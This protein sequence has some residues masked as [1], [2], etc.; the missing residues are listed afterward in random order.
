MKDAM[1]FH[2]P[3]NRD[4]GAEN[5]L[6]FVFAALFIASGCL[7]LT[8][9]TA[10]TLVGSTVSRYLNVAKGVFLF[11]IGLLL[12]GLA[13]A[14]IGILFFTARSAAVVKTP[15]FMHI[16]GEMEEE[17][18]LK[19]WAPLLIILALAVPLRLYGLNSDLWYDEV[20]T[21]V[22]FVRLPVFQLL[23][24]Y[25]DQ[26]NHPLFSLMAH[27]SVGVFGESAWALRV[28]AFVFGLGSLWALFLLARIVTNQREAI[29][30]TLLAAV[31]YH[32]VWFSQNA[33]GYTGLLFWGLLG[34]WLF[35]KGCRRNSPS[36]WA[37]YAVSMALG[38]YTHLTAGFVLISHVMIY[39][40]LVLF[41][42]RSNT[43]VS[44]AAWYPLA[45]FL[46]IGLFSFQL[47]ALILPQVIE[48]F[49]VQVGGG[50]VDA[51]TNPFWAVLEVIRGL[52]IGFGTSIGVGIA[53]VV[54]LSGLV[55]YGKGNP[56]V[57]WLFAIP[58]VTGSATLLA[59]HRH[60]YPRFFFFELGI[61]V[62][63]L[64]RGTTAISGFLTRWWITDN[65]K[66]ERI[67]RAVGTTIASMII[68][69]AALSL[70]QNYRYP[71][72]D[73][74]GPLRYIE[75]HRRQDDMIITAGHAS[76]PYRRYY[77]PYLKTVAT[78]EE[79]NEILFQN[80][81]I[82]LIYSFPDHMDSFFPG[83]R[84]VIEAHFT[85]MKEFPG[86]LGGGTLFVCRSA[87]MI[88]NSK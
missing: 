34:T 85:M 20:A 1:T 79:L 45:S 49:H 44:P 53:L 9:Q 88:D 30:A 17:A 41:R 23:T 6:L 31:S 87:Q 75:Q 5:L 68:V 43:F 25:G 13:L 73:Y 16:H 26:N 72:Q 10:F 62:L 50:R 82:W 15:A 19:T 7:L 81:T 78:V 8:Q 14:A 84:S 32:H 56:V 54:F 42:R 86:T 83:M 40:F 60:F 22:E 55:N 74:Q 37:G 69:V 24:T 28:P 65:M 64:I 70:Y 76:Y 35:I 21:L 63:I 59:L 29:L 66:Q 71:K 46:L 58:V 33:R 3:K 12:I 77:A 4:I 36:I 47:Y 52:R 80:K 18:S 67:G 2:R 51:W 38:M 61:G 11:K 27:A 57:V 39:G 48:S